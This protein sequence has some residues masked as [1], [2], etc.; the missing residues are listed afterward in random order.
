MYGIPYPM[1]QGRPHL[2]AKL[3]ASI[4]RA[5]CP[6]GLAPRAT[7]SSSLPNG[8]NGRDASNTSEG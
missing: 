4:G 3:T 6:N 1:S 5:E 8:T 7:P 2:S